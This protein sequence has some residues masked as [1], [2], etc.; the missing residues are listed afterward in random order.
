MLKKP[1][2]I[3]L[4]DENGK[5][6]DEFKL[7]VV[8]WRLMKKASAISKKFDEKDNEEEIDEMTE[9]LCEAFKNRFTPEDLSERGDASEIMQAINSIM[10]GIGSTAPNAAAGKAPQK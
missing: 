7:F 8:P 3:H 9:F 4:Y 1:A 6:T 5:A 2:I 10:E